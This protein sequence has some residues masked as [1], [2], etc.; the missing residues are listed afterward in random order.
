MAEEVPGLDGL[1]SPAGL[2]IRERRAG[3]RGRPG[4]LSRPVRT[5]LGDRLARGAAGAPRRRSRHPPRPRRPAG[6]AARIPRPTRS[7]ARSSTSGG[8]GP[9]NACAAPAGRC[10]TASFA[11]TAR[12][13]RPPG[14][15]CCSRRSATARWRA[16][17]K[18]AWQ[19]AGGWLERAL[20]AGDGLVRHGPR[21]APGGLAQQGWRDAEDP[22]DPGQSRRRHP[23]ARRRGSRSR[24]SPTPIRRLSRSSPCVPL[25]RSRARSAGGRRRRGSR[26]RSRSR[27]IPRRSRSR[28]TVRRW[29]GPVPSWA[30]CSGRMPSPG[31]PRA[32]GGAALPPRRAHALGPAHALLGASPVRSRRLPSR[33]RLAIR[34]LARLERAACRGPGAS[35]RAASPRD[36]G[37]DRVD[38]PERRSCSRSA[39]TG[40]SQSR[41]P[42][43]CRPGPWELAGRSSTNGMAVRRRS[44][45]RPG[46]HGAFSFV[47]RTFFTALDPEAAR[48]RR[49]EQ[50]VDSRLE[51]LT[52]HVQSSVRP[53][54]SRSLLELDSASFNLSTCGR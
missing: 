11:T 36:P 50:G 34:L 20:E 8:R 31:R 42:T 35:G 7:R 24:R 46:R 10:A 38:R 44:L 52:V 53:L 5:R 37:R 33:R 15:W 12:R 3:R 18:R 22:A 14:S 41:S 54:L 6:L 29:R 21:R 49:I 17:W 23:G 13:T 19:A 4:A 43:A 47:S 32:G 30:G 16:S 40:R 27:S 45:R 26:P 1:L 28:A 39:P 51:W 9:R 48:H 25:P 2:A